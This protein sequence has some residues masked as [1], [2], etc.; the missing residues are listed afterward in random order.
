MGLAEVNMET[1]LT[2]VHLFLALGLVGMVLMQHGKGADAGA[3]FGSGASATV[4]GAQGSANFLSRTTAVLAT[5]FFITSLWLAY[6]AMQTTETTSVMDV[7]PAAPVEAMPAP[8][9][10]SADDMPAIPGLPETPVEPAVE[11]D[12]PSVGT[13]AIEVPEESAAVEETVEQAAA[14]VPVV[15]EEAE[16]AVEEAQ[17]EVPVTTQE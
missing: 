8:A 5:L 2:V 10:Q 4:F 3:A 9:E 12:L 15:V 16:K 11:S 17:A 1:I 14:E 7:V 13:P 6:Y